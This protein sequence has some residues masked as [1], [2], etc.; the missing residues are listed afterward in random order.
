MELM[1]TQNR[2]TTELLKKFLSDKHTD[3]ELFELF[4]KVNTNELDQSLVEILP[5]NFDDV[6]INTS[7]TKEEI[8]ENYI[9]LCQNLT[10]PKK[11]GNID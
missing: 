8:Q 7:F 1:N 11:I 3:E 6:I 4:E 10:F 2:N 9:E 5:K